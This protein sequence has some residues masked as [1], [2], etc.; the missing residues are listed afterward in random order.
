MDCLLR[1]GVVNIRASQ[2][3]ARME[4]S[5]ARRWDERYRAGKYDYLHGSRE[6][7]RLR[8]LAQFVNESC[9]DGTCEIVDIGC[10]EGLLLGFL[11]PAKVARYVAVDLSAEALE[12]IA[13]SRVPV[14]KLRSSL[15]EWEG[16]PRQVAPRVI[17]A[18]EVLYYDPHGVRHLK[19]AIARAGNVRA[20]IV[21][22]VG[23][24]PEHPNWREPSERL[25][26]QLA[27]AGFGEPQWRRVED[28]G[29]GIVW[30][31][32]RYRP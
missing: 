25:W 3:E 4:V 8:A 15:G 9:I 2:T 16:G 12:R 13:P 20:V 11:D 10:G 17:V 22:C 7:A 6:M 23:G 14:V 5:Q 29:T 32:A 19:R 31:F 18:S 30:D 28:N 26:A 1:A 27:A 21:S 24:H